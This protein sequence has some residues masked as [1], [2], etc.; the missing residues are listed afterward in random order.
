[1]AMQAKVPIVPVII[2]NAHD[3]LPKGASIIRP[4]VVEVVIGK[5]IP[6]KRWKKENLDKHISKIRNLYLKELGQKE[7]TKK[8]KAKK[9]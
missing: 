3:A 9:K 2:K 4:S 1:M 6:T 8:R 7:K 5:P